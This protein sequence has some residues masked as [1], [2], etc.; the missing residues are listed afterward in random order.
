MGPAGVVWQDLEVGGPPE[1]LDFGFGFSDKPY[2]VMLLQP[3]KHLLGGIVQPGVF[4]G[5]DNVT[6]WGFNYLNDSGHAYYT[7][8]LLGPG[9]QSLTTGGALNE[10]EFAG[11]IKVLA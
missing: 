3:Y 8:R 2:P 7:L 9:S 11:F 6:T 5:V 10:G 1:E 4:L